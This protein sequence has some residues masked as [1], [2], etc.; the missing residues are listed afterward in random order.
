VYFRFAEERELL[1]VMEIRVPH[2][3]FEFATI[4]HIVARTRCIAFARGGAG[5]NSGCLDL[6][7]FP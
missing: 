5:A 4:P 3:R 1:F 2:C 7:D 6:T